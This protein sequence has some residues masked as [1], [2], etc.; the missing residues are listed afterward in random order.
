MLPLEQLAAG[1]GISACLSGSVLQTKHLPVGK[2]CPPKADTTAGVVIP[3]REHLHSTE[4]V[5]EVSTGL[6]SSDQ[7]AASDYQ[8]QPQRA[9]HTAAAAD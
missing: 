4:E 3:A 6:K 2:L 9:H 8:T 5:G 1:K 7:L